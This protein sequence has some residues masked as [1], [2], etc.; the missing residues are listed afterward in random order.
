MNWQPISSAPRDGQRF[1]ATL[2]VHHAKD[3]SFSHHDM[4]VIAVDDETGEIDPDFDQGWGI[5][6]YEFWMPL[7][8]PPEYT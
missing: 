6:D 7:P 3:G 2:R 1:L 4:H 8:A 5:E